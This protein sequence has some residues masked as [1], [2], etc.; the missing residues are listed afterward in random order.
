MEPSSLSEQN[1]AP[2]QEAPTPRQLHSIK[3][4]LDLVLLALEALTGLGSD[5]ML[6]AAESLGVSDLLSDRV[7]LWRL[8]QASPLRKGQGRK[9]LDIDEARA[10]VLV[11][12]HL[13]TAHRDPIRQAVT[14]LEQALGQGQ[15]PHRSAQLGDYLDAFSNAYQDR[16]EGDQTATTDELTT[17]GLKLLVDLL[18]YSGAGGSRKLWV[19]LLDRAAE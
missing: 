16:M 10:L 9:K 1:P 13:A 6:A 3:A 12:C 19:T 11:S 14:R 4:Q 7:N 18:F 17:L 8:R 5:A 2:A 15:P